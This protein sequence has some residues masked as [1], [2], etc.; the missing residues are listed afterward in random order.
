MVNRHRGSS[1]SPHFRAACP[2]VI[3]SASE[4]SARSFSIGPRSAVHGPDRQSSSDT[5]RIPGEVDARGGLGVPICQATSGRA[6]VTTA[7]HLRFVIDGQ[8]VQRRPAVPVT[9]IG[10]FSQELA[11]TVL[12]VGESCASAQIAIR[13]HTR[14]ESR[15][16]LRRRSANSFM[17]MKKRLSQRASFGRHE[18]GGFIQCCERILRFQGLIKK[19]FS[20]AAS[21]NRATRAHNTAW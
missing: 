11:D 15:A 12:E 9:P 3:L 20:S 2:K 14:I 16:R 5:I 19:A 6:I 7:G 21:V 8:C 1:A 4:E 10:N 13:D 17:V 18:V